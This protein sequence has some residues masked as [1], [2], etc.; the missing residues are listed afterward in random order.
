[1]TL[2]ISINDDAISTALRS[3]LLSLITTEVDS[4]LTNRVAQPPG[5]AV[6]FTPLSTKRLATN[7][8]RFDDATQTTSSQEQTEKIYQ[9]D[10]YGALSGDWATIINLKWRSPSAVLFL[11]PLGVIPLFSEDPNQVPFINGEDQ[12]E[13]RWT[14]KLHL[15]YNP[16]VSTPQDSI[17]SAS[18]TLID[19]DRVYTP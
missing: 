15:Q 6:I 17:T 19:T 12:Y 13:E 3:W 14:L 18:V 11:K 5:P 8:E 9:V 10:C 4:G 2:L 16:V 1:M 7:E